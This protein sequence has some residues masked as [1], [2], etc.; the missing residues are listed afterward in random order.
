MEHGNIPYASLMTKGV[1]VFVKQ[2]KLVSQ[3]AESV[4]AVN[5]E[6]IKNSLLAVPSTRI[7]LSRVQPFVKTKC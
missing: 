5:D 6:F 2:P 1:I 4:I 3:L 7:T